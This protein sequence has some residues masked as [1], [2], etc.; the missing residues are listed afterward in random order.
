MPENITILITDEGKKTLKKLP[1]EAQIKILKK[2]VEYNEKPELITSQIK[3][4]TDSHPPM[5]RLRIGNFRAVGRMVGNELHLDIFMDRK[6]L[7]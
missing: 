2:I 1:K 7:K 3:H 6:N 5:T 4:M